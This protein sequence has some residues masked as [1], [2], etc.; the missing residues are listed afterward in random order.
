MRS[1]NK[2][3]TAHELGDML[4]SLTELGRRKGIKANEALDFAARRFL[5]RYAKMEELAAARGAILSELS[6]DEQDELW[7]LAKEEEEGSHGAA[8]GDN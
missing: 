6:L 5:S 7:N 1:E 8:K 2:E 4:F 3:A